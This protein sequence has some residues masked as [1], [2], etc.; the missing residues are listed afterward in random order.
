[1]HFPYFTGDILWGIPQPEGG[2]TMAGDAVATQ[3]SVQP[4]DIHHPLV[5]RAIA[6]TERK[7]REDGSPFDHTFEDMLQA[8]ELPLVT[9]PESSAR[10]EGSHP[11]EIGLW[12][13]MY[14]SAERPGVR[15][16]EVIQGDDVSGSYWRFDGAY[17]A[18]SGNGR[19]GDLPGDFKFMYGAAV[20][21]DEVAGEGIYAIYGSGWVHTSLDDPLGSRFMPPFQGAAGGPSGGPLFTVHGRDIDMFFLPLGVRPGAMLETGDTFRMAGPIMPTLPSRVEYTVTTPD[22][23]TR[24]FDGR[25]NAVGY[26]YDPADDFVLDQPGLWTVALQVTHDGLTSAGPVQEPYPTGGPLTSDGSTFTFVVTGPETHALE[27]ETDLAR[28]TPAEWYTNVR[29]STFEAGLPSG[30]TGETVRVIVT[31]PGIV[32]VD[33]EVTVRNDQIRWEL[34]AHALNQLASNFDYERGIADTITVTF[35]AEDGDAQAAGTIV[36]HGARVPVAPVAAR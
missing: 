7:A 18:Q 29:R 28:L 21:R 22:G 1:M 16:R 13:Y 32:L 23:T 6:Q 5:A 12:A 25:A 10:Q 2:A 20:I 4:L 35:Y 27:V 9:M 24:T 34:H 30:W 36:T 14:S 15:V 3:M 33:E 8:G 31:M 26:F 17:H 11:D 19:E